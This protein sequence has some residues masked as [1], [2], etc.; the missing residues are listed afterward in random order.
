VTR[1]IHVLGVWVPGHVLVDDDGT[2]LGAIA[3]HD[4]AERIAALL[5]RHGLADIP[6]D[7]AALC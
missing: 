4:V 1:V 5:D 2:I 3:D 7:A 6:D